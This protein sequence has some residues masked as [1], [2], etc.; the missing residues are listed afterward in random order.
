MAS[1][2]PKFKVG[3]PVISF[4]GVRATVRNVIPAHK[5]SASHRVEVD[6]DG[7]PAGAD[8][9]AYYEEV[10]L[11]RLPPEPSRLDKRRQEIALTSEYIENFLRQSAINGDPVSTILA[12][13]LSAIHE[14]LGDILK[15][16]IK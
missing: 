7:E 5:L 6:W 1:G 14:R 13:G 2:D 8:K 10:F 4:R 15:E 16:L 9:T 3:D 12:H 11:P